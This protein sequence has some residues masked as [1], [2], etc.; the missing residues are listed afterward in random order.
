[1]DAAVCDEL[2]AAA[3]A[4]RPQ[5]RLAGPSRFD[6]AVAISREQFPAGAEEVY[7]ARAVDSPD[8]VA[9]GSLSAGPILLV[10]T[11]GAVPGTV[12]AEI[13]RL[14]PA[15]VI[16]LGGDAAV[17]DEVLAEAAAGR[18]TQRL[19]GATRIETA[20]AISQ[21]RFP[22][23]GVASA[24]LAR[25]DVFADAVA[26]GSL[27]DGPILLVPSCGAPPAAVAGEIARLGPQE[28]VALG[29]A[30]A[31]CDGLL[32]DA[33]ADP[34]LPPAEPVPPADGP[35]DS[36]A[37]SAD[38]R[39]VTFSSEAS[40][41]VPGD[42]N[43]AADV[44]VRDQAALVTSRISLGPL[45]AQSDG[46]STQPA[47]SS[48]GRYIA[49]VSMATNLPGDTNGVGD[50]FVHDR[51]TGVTSRVSVAGGGG[52]ADGPSGEPALSADG[53]F[54]GFSSQAA[55]LVPGD[56]NG[57]GDVFVHDRDTGETSR[58][59][60][61]AA[62]SQAQGS[63]AGPS[64]SADGRYV[65]FQS[66]A[67]MVAIDVNETSDVYVRDRATSTTLWASEGE[68]APNNGHS[69]GPS[70]SADGRYVAFQ[71][72]SPLLSV[73]TN[74]VSDI[75]EYEL[76]TGGT[77]RLSFDD[78]RGQ[79]D[80]ASGSAAISADG[81]VTAFVSAA[82]SLVPAA[83]STA[84]Q[85]FAHR[86]DL[87][88]RT[89]CLVALLAVVQTQVDDQ[90]DGLLWR[91]GSNSDG[92]F[93]PRP[94]TDTDGWPDNGLSVWD[95]LAAACTSSPG[96]G[97]AQGLNRVALWAIG[98]L[99]VRPDLSRPGHFFVAADSPQLHAE[100]AAT[101]PGVITKPP[102]NPPHRLTVELTDTIVAPNSA[103]PRRS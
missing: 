51:D 77:F 30:Q 35:S 94:G 16:A 45:G 62:G 41:L 54:V 52:Q 78:V 101:R 39:L 84:P 34:P 74:G 11:A 63:S 82:T 12:M 58:V 53:R 60:V 15:R 66:D 29:G 73:D 18:A 1:G 57:V 6:T 17:S 3:A 79:A 98:E 5:D 102:T 96:S 14:E 92:N 24:Y 80:G 89:V 44:F 99:L 46:D 21:N 67:Q 42:G 4:G 31:V 65:A 64:V 26:G 72:D 95:T 100:W 85:V 69:F 36:P 49:F 70:V 83:T 59:S 47:I 68:N 50:L 91:A 22:G 27:A 10:P 93:T 90:D 87:L 88:T 23:G 25:A 40:N 9:A 97:K 2:L 32:E 8:A 13:A 55:N 7:L 76:A 56:T 103:C 37:V 86:W 19:A 75:Y 48:D 33:A 81:L 61:D 28:V 43:G 71:S 20:L 38:G